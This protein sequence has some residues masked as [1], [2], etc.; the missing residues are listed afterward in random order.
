MTREFSDELLSAYLDDQLT[1][2]ERAEVEAHLAADPAARQMLDE[3]RA[4]SGE[5][6]SL[7]AHRAGSD[8]ANRV[9][10][11]ALAAKGQQPQVAAAP[12]R[13]WL[14]ATVAALAATAAAIAIVV[15]QPFAGETNIAQPLSPIDQ[16][17]A[18]IAEQ[19]P[20]QDEAIIVRVR[21][22]AG[23]NPSQAVDLALAS[24]GIQQRSPADTASG[25]IEVGAAYR[26]HLG[27]KFAAQPGV[28]NPALTAGTAPVVDAVFI[29]ATWEHVAA[30]L[31]ELMATT[32]TL[33]EVSPL[34]TIAAA[35]PTRAG[36]TGGEA[37]GTEPL[38]GSAAAA[39]AEFAQRL[40]AI[41]YRVEKSAAADRPAAPA[42]AIDA[43]R[44]VRVLVLI[45]TLP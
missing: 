7:P 26:K 43:Q 38:P 11:A 25:A 14:A 22:P 44:R 3:L 2:A 17:L 13:A 39:S 40:P 12:R 36:Q 16:A 29:E 10:A 33:P 8:F 41:M 19:L 20:G 9:V 5:V 42:T 24:A 27:E 35:R 37:E 15:W 30:A 21:V 23:M 31:T 1:A 45:E 34:A 6:R 4:L 32:A 28:P 18:S